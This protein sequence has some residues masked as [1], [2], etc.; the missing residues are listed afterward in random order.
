MQKH[1]FKTD[2][3]RPPGPGG[4]GRRVRRH[5]RDVD[6]LGRHSQD[7]ASIGPKLL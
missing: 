3:E 6:A 5:V 4:V 7:T 2:P 1:K